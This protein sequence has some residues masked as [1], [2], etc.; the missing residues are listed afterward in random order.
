MANPQ[1]MGAYVPTTNIWDVSE[2]YAANIKDPALQE[3]L[4]RLYQNLNLMSLGVNIKDSGYYVYDNEFVNGQLYFPNPALSSS[5]AQYPAFRQ[6]FRKLVNFGAL[7]SNAVP[8]SVNHDIPNINSAFTFTRIYA[9]ASN[10]TGLTYI[11]IP[12]VS[13]SAIAN[14]LELSVDST[15]VTIT[16]GGTDYSAYTI[17]YVI[18]EYLKQ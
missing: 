14:N 12:Y 5:T 7:P 1:N 4:I 13:A 15:Q 10:T 8:K 6:V 3:L 9:V 11:P 17:C 18:L 16:S 2:V